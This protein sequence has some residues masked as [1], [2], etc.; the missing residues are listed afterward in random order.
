MFSRSD[1]VLEGDGRT[2][3]DKIAITESP[4]FA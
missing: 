4:I 2:D 1:T 3:D